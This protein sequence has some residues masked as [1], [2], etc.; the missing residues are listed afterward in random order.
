MT[1]KGDNVD[2]IAGGD[3]AFAKNHGKVNITH[4]HYHQYPLSPTGKPLQR[5]APVEHFTGR[6]KEL[7]DLLNN[8]QPGRVITL[9]GPG[10]VGKT[11]LVSKA[12][13]E[14]S[15]DSAPPERF[16]DGIIFYCFYGRPEIG[17]AFEH[18]VKSFDKNENDTSKDAAFRFL[19]GK[20]V[21]LILDGVEE[22]DNFGM[23]LEIRDNCGIIVTSRKRADAVNAPLNINSME[24]NEAVAL[25]QKWA[26]IQ[27]EDEN[28]IR[29]ICELTG[30]LPLAVRLAGRYIM[31]TGERP[32]QYLK[33]LKNTPLEALD[34][35]ERKLLSVPLLIEKSLEHLGKTARKILSIIGVLAFAS[36]DQKAIEAGFFKE[37]KRIKKFINN[38][39]RT[40]NETSIKKINQSLNELIGY[41]LLSRY[42]D[43]YQV[44]HALIY[45]YSRTKLWADNRTVK[46]LTLYYM[47]FATK[48]NQKG[49]EGYNRLD[50]ER[51][52]IIQLIDSCNNRL[53]LKKVTDLVFVIDDYLNIRGYWT[54]R[55]KALK[56]GLESARKAFN[57]IFKAYFSDYLGS[58]YLNIGK[59]E[60]AINY[61]ESSLNFISKLSIFSRQERSASLTNLGVAYNELGQFIKAIDYHSQALSLKRKI[62]DR[63]GEAL[64]LT[65]IAMAYRSLGDMEKAFEYNENALAITQGNE[66]YS[67]IEGIVQGNLGIIYR[68]IGNF[69]K[70]VK[71]HEHALKIALETG[72]RKHEGVWLFNLGVDHQ[73]IGDLEKSHEYEIQA[74]AIFEDIKSPLAGNA[75]NGLLKLKFECWLP[76]REET[77]E[78]RN[79]NA[80]IFQDEVVK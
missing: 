72:D 45:S 21:L 51:S 10:G 48:E 33:F 15:P 67:I 66:L 36:L 4:T 42:G 2:I 31:E 43:R 55:I 6:V 12:V 17:L 58:A 19:S 78:L 60:T 70:A 34:F 7:K 1:S 35:G 16:P 28:I 71:Y 32:E 73:F 57:P 75:R 64:T 37:E 41:S 62:G 56:M 49:L 27:K 18:I 8:I 59:T 63:K 50:P 25:F 22:A 54:E 77:K 52:H 40:Q 38:L 79:K 39:F 11:A 14:L 65:N 74:L 46:R 5:P 44:S 61:Y 68:D 80:L 30:G 47:R 23:I 76:T 13:W 20:K 69:K 29:R 26:N 24:N 53:M 9:C 3:V